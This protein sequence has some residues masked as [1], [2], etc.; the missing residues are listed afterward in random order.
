MGQAPL[1]ERGADM[2]G[3]G[4]GGQLRQDDVVERGRGCPV[5]LSQ[6]GRRPDDDA[7]GPRL[8]RSLFGGLPQAIGAA[9]MAGE[10]SA[11]L[12]VNGWRRR[13][14]EVREKTGESL[15]LV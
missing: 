3:Q 10:I 14:P 6:T 7:A 11:D 13:E 4:V 12:D 1:G 9:E 8:G 15:Q 2:A 5:A